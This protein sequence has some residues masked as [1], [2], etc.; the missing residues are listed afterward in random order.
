MKRAGIVK[1]AVIFLLLCGLAGGLALLAVNGYM[2]WRVRSYIVSPEEAGRLPKVDCV[3]VL[4]CGVHPDGSPTG[5]LR[6]RMNQGISLYQAGVSDRLLMSGDHGR[7]N[8]DEVNRM[9][10]MAVDAGVPSSAVFMDHAGFSTYDSMYRA[11]DIFQVKRMVVVTQNYHMYRAL[12]VARSM[13]I[14][15]YGVSAWS[16]RYGGQLKRDLRELLARPKDLLYTIVRPAPTYLGDAIP[17]SGD[18]NVTNDKET[19][20]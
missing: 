16:P 3:M 15:A 5:M 6:D 2:V 11:R 13:G 4:G 19:E 10:Q 14:D 9:K 17:V 18:G 8:Y 12:Y 20:E 1:R 7:E